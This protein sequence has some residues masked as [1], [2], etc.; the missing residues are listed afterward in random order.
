[1]NSAMPPS[2]GPG[3]SRARI[4]RSSGE[5]RPDGPGAAGRS[6]GALLPPAGF[7]RALV[8]PEPVT[9]RPVL[10]QLTRDR[11]E[12]LVVELAHALPVGRT[13]RRDLRERRDPSGQVVAERVGLDLQ[14]RATLTVLLV[15]AVAQPAVHDDGLARL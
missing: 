14:H 13:G 5:G 6:G 10:E 1:M 8:G 7:R 2:L 12:G 3:G 15:A 11:V 4:G 9:R